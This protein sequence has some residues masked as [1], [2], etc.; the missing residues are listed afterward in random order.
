MTQDQIIKHASQMFLVNGYKTTTMDDLAA[1]IGISKKTLYEFFGNKEGLIRLSLQLQFQE[2]STIFS[3]TKSLN[4]NAV[5]EIQMIMMKIRSQ[6][7]TAQRF[8]SIRQLQKYYAKIYNKVYLEQA[9]FIQ[10]SIKENI[11]KGQANGLYRSE[12]N[13]DIFAE[14]FL[15]I[16][17]YLRT[18][19]QKALDI[20]RIESLSLLHFELMI[21]G[22]LTPTGLEEF[23]K[24]EIENH[25]E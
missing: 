7:I 21:R 6:F 8:N 12:V 17:S 19:Q 18:N 4:L 20:N 11:L 9:I 23:M 3:E 5:S 13:A 14:I 2:I 1:D 25:E 10:N 24:F 22:I 16:Q 15:E